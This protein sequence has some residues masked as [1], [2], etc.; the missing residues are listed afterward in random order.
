MKKLFFIILIC[1]G[2]V[3]SQG[4]RDIIK[5]LNLIAGR[6]DSVMLSDIFYSN[7]YTVKFKPGKYIEF[8]YSPSTKML[9]LAAKKGFEGIELIEFTINN[10][11]Y[12]IP[13]KSETVQEKTF[14][15]KPEG[16]FKN[17]NLFG[18]F[19]S[20]NRE[21]LTMKDA[22]N[23]GIYEITI[24]LQPG[25]Y[26]Y[27][28]YV[29]GKEIVDPENPVFIPNGM[30]DFNSIITINP[31]RSETSYLHFLKREGH[32]ITFFYERGNGSDTLDKSHIIALINNSVI[33]EKRVSVSGNYIT[34]TLQNSDFGRNNILRTVVDQDGLISNIQ[35]LFLDP[36]IKP[37]IKQNRTTHDKII[38]SVMIDRFSDGDTTINFPVVHPEIL[39]PANYQ[40]GDFQ[41]IL[42][43]IN[44]G[45]FDSLG[46]NTLWITPVNDNTEKAFREY[47][48]P[49]RYYSGYHGYWP[50]HS[51][52]VEE[53]FGDMKTLKNMVTTAQRKGM[54]VL[55][56]YVANHIHIDHPLWQT[57]RNW[58]GKLELP[59]GSLNLRLWD[60]QRLTTW[61]EPYM[62]SF[63]FVSSTSA[64]EYMTDNAVWWLQETN[65]DGFRHD[66]VKHVPNSF[67]RRLTEK[68]KSRLE[69]DGRKIYQIGE[70]FGSYDLISS[71]VNNGQLDAQF[72]FNLYDVAIPVFLTP[73]ASFSVLD[74]E[75]KKTFSVYGV[76]H[77]MGNLM[78]SHDKP[79]FMAYAD[80]DLPLG[81][82]GAGEMAWNDPPVVDDPENYNYLKI[83][84]AYLNSI[85]GVPIIYYGDE[86]G[87]TG[88][89]DPDNRRM[90]RFGSQVNDLERNVLNEVRKIITARGLHTALRYGDFRTLHADENVYVYMRSDLNERI[91][92]AINKSNQPQNVTVVL[93][94]VYGISRAEDL[95]KK[96]YN[97]KVINHTMEL[98]ILPLDYTYL[99]LD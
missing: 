81:G 2:F 86:I 5:P 92:I 3:Y 6:T 33:P 55:L 25:R 73:D 11:D 77:L 38:Y 4:I 18:S 48:P 54:K 80:G 59:D 27:K 98:N 20:W 85:P 63:D 9:Y 30:G 35:T 28:F 41:G 78:D 89:A 36:Q 88:A 64:L 8:S 46:V 57:K 94:S 96:N 97:A 60:E 44:E 23:D 34:V 42:N 50:V 51:T 14:K 37:G 84:M 22:D 83:Y 31:S 72:N 13:V 74:L 29:D 32:I 21:E 1:A 7:N 93:P 17:V 76:N 52:R 95:L 39:K 75:M 45:Y 65:I 47:P 99:K 70:T 24:P 68:V 43:K 15:Y 26:E 49:H 90:M 16:E 87:M 58:F 62:P 56:D 71:Y 10:Q 19:N 79:R 82:A 61:F 40:G 67:W 69:K 12:V 66:A 53:N 91:L